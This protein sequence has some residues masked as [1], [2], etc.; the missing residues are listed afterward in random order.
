MDRL[1]SGYYRV[2]AGGEDWPLRT[3]QLKNAA[4]G[5]DFLSPYP[6]SCAELAGQAKSS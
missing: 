2:C 6:C 5:S 4:A 3:N 1:S